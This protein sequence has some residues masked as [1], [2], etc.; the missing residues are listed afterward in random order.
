MLDTRKQLGIMQTLMSSTLCNPGIVK[1][2]LLGLH[3]YLQTQLSTL[4]L[5][6][7]S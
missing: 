3:M 1:L 5:L 4:G 7:L 6:N 2:L